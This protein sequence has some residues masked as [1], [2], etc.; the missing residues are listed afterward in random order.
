MCKRRR[1][2]HRPAAHEDR[3]A[4]ELQWLEDIIDALIQMT[5][6]CVFGILRALLLLPVVIYRALFR[7]V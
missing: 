3:D 1:R 5:F 7:S 2:F 4:G 6:Y